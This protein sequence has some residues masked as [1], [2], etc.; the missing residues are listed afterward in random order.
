MVIRLD[1]DANIIVGRPYIAGKRRLG[2]NAPRGYTRRSVVYTLILVVTG[3]ARSYMVLRVKTNGDGTWWKE[4]QINAGKHRHSNLDCLQ[5]RGSSGEW[6]LDWDYANRSNY[7]NHGSY[8]TWHLAE[9]KF[10][11]SLEEPF[12]M[13]TAWRWVDDSCPLTEISH[14]GFCQACEDLRIRRI[15]IM[16]DSLSIEFAQSIQSLLGFAPRST[17]FNAR[18]K[19][20]PIPCPQG[21]DIVFLTLRRSSS[22]DF[23]NLAMTDIAGRAF[24]ETRTA[25]IANLGAWFHSMD[26]YRQSFDA[27]LDWIDSL[28][29]DAIVP[30]F[31]PT[32]PGHT[33][34]KPNNGNASFLPVHYE[35][36]PLS[37]HS[38][39][40]R[41]YGEYVQDE[42]RLRELYVSNDAEEYRWDYFESFNRYSFDKIKSR[43]CNHSVTNIHWLNVYNSSILRR[44]GHVGFGDCLHYYLPGPIDWWTHFFH[45]ALLDLN[46]VEHQKKNETTKDADWSSM[47]P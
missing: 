33:G 22:S 40:Y 15:L 37:F 23:V 10:Q 43:A 3:L 14:E 4:Q 36:P 41:S 47:C 2:L 24:I 29:S 38:E 7:P 16:G 6:M 13:A 32:I 9:Q 11:P 46:S 18:F 45:S 39:P 27:L 8:T 28:D 42:K 44:D 12:R 35:W 20:V 31:R 26:E 1:A 17:G 5:R 34:C 30:F 19:P 25:I 21:F